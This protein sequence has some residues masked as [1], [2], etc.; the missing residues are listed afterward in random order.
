[1]SCEFGSCVQTVQIFLLCV[2]TEFCVRPDLS[3]FHNVQQLICSTGM[4]YGQ[5]TLPL[6]DGEPSY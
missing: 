6:Q 2:V 1:M 3:S 4:K 5:N